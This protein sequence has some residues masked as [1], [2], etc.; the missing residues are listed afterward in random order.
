MVKRALEAATPEALVGEAQIPVRH[1]REFPVSSADT[2]LVLIDMQTD[3]LSKE[4]RLGK[5]Y[6]AERVKQ[7]AAT[8][9][10][11]AALI[12]AA[13]KAGMTIAHSRSHRYGAQVRVDLVRPTVD[14]TYDLV[15]SCRPLPGEIVV[16]KW[17]FGAFASTDLEQQ[18]RKRGVKRI[19]LAGILT[20]V[21]IMATAVQAVD[22]FFR[23]CLVEDCCGAFDP[24][25]HEQALNLI[26][27]PQT[28]KENHH[29]CVGLYFGEV[30]TL[31]DAQQA[32]A[33]CSGG[34]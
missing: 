29:K 34:T 2:A 8:E 14:P 15:E 9:A 3:F 32:L 16:D 24:Q 18:L 26:N 20:N 25:W 10:K 7:L 30:A 12:A 27:G 33:K 4:G 23:V 5:N 1:D 22:R 6:D 31:A 13:R 17:T 11:V 21:C 19:L 28:M